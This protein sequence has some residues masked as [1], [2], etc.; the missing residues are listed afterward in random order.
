L[1]RETAKEVHAVNS[2]IMRFLGYPT[3]LPVLLSVCG[4]AWAQTDRAPKEGDRAPGFSITTDQGKRISP[5]AFGGGLLVLNFW[6]TSCVPCVKEMPSLSDFA[7]KFRS[8]HVIV[9]AVG[10]DEDA[11][12]YRRFLRDRRIVLETY[13]DPDRRISKSFGTYMFPETYIIQ[14]G[15]IIRKIVGAIDWMSDDIT[16]FVRTHLAVIGR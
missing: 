11:Q 10:G 14:D 2:V 13:R 7:R 6:E 15:R 3:I 9:V 1:Q 4:C 12:K 16:A 5:G 8:E